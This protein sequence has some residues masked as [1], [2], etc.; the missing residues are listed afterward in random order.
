M[1]SFRY[2]ASF[3]TLASS[4]MAGAQS[5][6]LVDPGNIPLVDGDFMVHTGPY[7][8]PAAAG[9]G[10]AYDFSALVETAMGRESCRDMV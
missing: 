3:L 8:S 7:M 10:Q 1:A 4:L 9:P 6:T 2:A 5:I